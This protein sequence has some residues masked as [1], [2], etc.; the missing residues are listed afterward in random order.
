[1]LWAS[2]PCQD[3]SNAAGGPCTRPQQ[4]ATPAYI[5]NWIRVGRP[6]VYVEENV[7]E[8]TQKWSGWA[9]HVKEIEARGYRVEV[10]KLDAAD[11][12]VPQ[13]RK[14]LILIAVRDDGPI[15]WAKPTHSDP[16]RLL[17]G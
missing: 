11:Y 17:P 7:W 1:L 8:I 6:K 2:A 12:G 5:L 9:Q 4:R 16:E 13:H 10:R 15:A 3:W 14:R